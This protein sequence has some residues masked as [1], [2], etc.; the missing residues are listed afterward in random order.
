MQEQLESAGF[1]EDSYEQ[2]IRRH[3]RWNFAVNASDLIA[4]NLARSFIFSSTILTLYASYLTHSAI[5]IGLIPAVQK[6]GYLLPQLILARRAEGMDRKKPFVVRVSV[7]ERV[8]Y[9]VI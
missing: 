5:L 2:E 3:R 7:V 9:L 1:N 4:V 6:V 8:P